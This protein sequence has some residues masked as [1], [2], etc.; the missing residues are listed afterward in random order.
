MFD[1]Y[2]TRDI[3][4]LRSFFSDDPA[5]AAYLL[6]DLDAPYFNA[7]RWFVAATHARP[8]AVLL[9]FE[10]LGEPVLLSHGAPDGVA[11]ICDGFASELALACWAKIPIAHREAFESIFSIIRAQ[12]LWTMELTNF[13]PVDNAGVVP[14]SESNLP[15]ML[16]LYEAGA[17]NYFQASQMPAA[18]YFGR[19]DNGR[20][21]SVAGTH[22]YSPREHVAVLGNIVTAE[23]ARNRGHARAVTSRLIEELH[24]RGC[25]TIALQVA[26]DNAP[27][28]ATYRELGFVFRDVVLQARC[29]R[30]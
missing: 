7:C 21:L 17:E 29:E 15:E 5:R 30:P 8:V 6:G 2:V 4:L 22:V 1:T 20:I 18:V 12:P 23:D 25:T 3:A 24:R 11:A 27:A 10:A 9:S 26:A 13:R 19:Y 16:S 14:L 28:I